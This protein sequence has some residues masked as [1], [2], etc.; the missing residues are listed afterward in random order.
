MVAAQNVSSLCIAGIQE[1]DKGKTNF[2]KKK[3]IEEAKLKRQD[4]EIEIR[5]RRRNNTM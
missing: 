4:R 5:D 2:Q 3:K 1:T